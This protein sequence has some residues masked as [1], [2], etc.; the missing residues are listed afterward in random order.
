MFLTENLATI[1]L[2]VSYIFA[3]LV[4][5][6]L[7]ILIFPFS[8]PLFFLSYLI[9][10]HHLYLSHSPFFFSFLFYEPSLPTPQSLLC[11]FSTHPLFRPSYQCTYILSHVS[12]LILYLHSPKKSSLFFPSQL[13]HPSILKLLWIGF[14]YISI[15]IDTHN[16]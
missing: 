6:M 10:Y 5:L 2:F 11:P 8:V 1:I 7:L 14:G 4:F 13:N 16:D 3:M 12:L 9:Y 15:P